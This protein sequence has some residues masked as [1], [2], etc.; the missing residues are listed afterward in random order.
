MC[1]NDEAIL[2]F[3][4]GQLQFERLMVR[5]HRAHCVI[6]AFMIV[7]RTFGQWLRKR[8]NADAICASSLYCLRLHKVSF[9]LSKLKHFR[10][11]QLQSGVFNTSSS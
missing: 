11:L 6:I 4:T 3:D 8:R 1:L 10:H 7:S 5:S 2:I 9:G